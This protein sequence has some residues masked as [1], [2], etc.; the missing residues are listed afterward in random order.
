[1][2]TQAP[3]V[4]GGERAPGEGPSLTPGPRLEGSLSVLEKCDE[5]DGHMP[6]LVRIPALTGT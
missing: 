4:G 3:T 1:M 5:K 2:G 6:S